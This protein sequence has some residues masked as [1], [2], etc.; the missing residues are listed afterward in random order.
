[1]ADTE[2]TTSLISAGK[3]QGTQFIT[4]LARASARFMI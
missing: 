2:E 3:V 1:M 4:P